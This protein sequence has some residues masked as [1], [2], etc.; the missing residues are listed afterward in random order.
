MQ[1]AKDAATHRAGPDGVMEVIGRRFA[2]YPQPERTDGEWDAWWADYIETLQDRP[3][4][5]LEAAMREWVASP[6]AEFLPRPGKLLA[7]SRTVETDEARLHTKLRKVLEVAPRLTGPM[8]P[9]QTVREMLSEFQASCAKRREAKPTYEPPP[10]T[11]G[12]ADERGLTPEM[13][14]VM[15]RREA[16]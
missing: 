12:K 1:L 8:V 7:M 13:R 4:A 11:H 10:A 2:M 6:D 5:S 3:Y 16:A 14:A 15:D 9:K